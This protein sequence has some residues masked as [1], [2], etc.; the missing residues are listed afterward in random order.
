[1]RDKVQPLVVPRDDAGPQLVGLVRLDFLVP[2]ARRAAEDH[3]EVG[4]S[5]DGV[6]GLAEEDEAEVAPRHVHVGEVGRVGFVQVVVA[7]E[8][9]RPCAAD[10]GQEETARR[11]VFARCRVCQPPHEG[12]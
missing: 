5:R 4:R 12:S 2:R 7:L 8:R 10:G 9:R 6:E 1:M 11:K 3:G